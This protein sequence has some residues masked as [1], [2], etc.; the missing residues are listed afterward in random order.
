MHTP[1]GFY[2]CCGVAFSWV[3]LLMLLGCAARAR[4][5]TAAERDLSHLVAVE[6]FLA[7][8]LAQVGELGL[9]I[10]IERDAREFQSL[11]ADVSHDGTPFTVEEMQ[12]LSVLLHDL[13]LALP[14]LPEDN[15]PGPGTG[16]R[17][18]VI[19]RPA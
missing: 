17:R 8:L 10:E 12:D 9:P 3:D 19:N 4:L 18:G 5:R 15:P 6:A 1:T 11:V 16:R 2:L 13:T 7:Q 14:Y